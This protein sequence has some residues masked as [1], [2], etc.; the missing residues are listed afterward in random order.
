MLAWNAVGML[1]L[2][3]LTPVEE[4]GTASG[5]VLFGFLTGWAA[6]PWIFGTAVDALDNYAVGWAMVTICFLGSAAI[7]PAWRRTHRR[8]STE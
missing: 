6:T 7:L 3:T 4:T 8:L 2:L 5:T 1:A